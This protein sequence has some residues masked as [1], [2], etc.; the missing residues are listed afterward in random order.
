MSS[1][2][3]MHLSPSV[4]DSIAWSLSSSSLFSVKSFFLA[5]SNFSN[6]I[7]FL[8]DKFLWSS[9]AP[10]KVKALAWLGSTWE[11]KHQW[12]AAIEK[13]LQIPLSLVVHSMQ[14]KW[15]IDRPPFS[16]LSFTYRALALA[17]QSSRV[18]LGS[19]KE[20]C[21]HDVLHLKVWGTQLEARHF[22]KSLASLC[23]ELCGKKETL[24]FL[25]IRGDEKGCYGIYFISIPLYELLVLLLLEEFLLVFYNSTGLWFV[26]QK[27]EIVGDHL[28]I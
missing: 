4:A 14:R 25:R 10:S 1:L 28:C 26:I 16:P 9:K 7:L 12:Q 15:R 6:P 13:T 20:Y 3:S 5:L 22:G 17:L 21:G 2:S 19:T 8:L 24:G 27:F 23:C 18:R 11:G